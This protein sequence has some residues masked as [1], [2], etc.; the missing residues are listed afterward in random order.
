[1]GCGSREGEVSPT[2][3]LVGL[4]GPSTTLTRESAGGLTSTG[5][6]RSPVRNEIPLLQQRLE[7]LGAQHLPQILRDELELLCRSPVI[8][9]RV[10]QAVQSEDG[11]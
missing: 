9:S 1:M 3:R 2:L 4:Q 7:L 8:P 6:R 11:A 5:R 10:V